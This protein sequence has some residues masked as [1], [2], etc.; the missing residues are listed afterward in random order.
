MEERIL[1]VLKEINEDIIDYEGN[2][3]LEDDVIDSFG[4]IDIISGLEEEFD[5]EIDADYVVPENFANKDAI[6]NMMKQIMC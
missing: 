2:T 6:I 5:I 4:V 3:M 1:K